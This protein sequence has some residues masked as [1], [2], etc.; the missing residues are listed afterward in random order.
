LR[1][2]GDAP[3]GP[4]SPDSAEERVNMLLSGL[5]GIKEEDMQ[6][7]SAVKLANRNVEL[8]VEVLNV[9]NSLKKCL[10]AHAENLVSSRLAGP[11]KQ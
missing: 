3:D 11:N 8:H 6:G 9:V 4:V 5:G 1:D 2:G 10:E 7:C